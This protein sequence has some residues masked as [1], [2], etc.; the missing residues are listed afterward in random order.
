MDTIN[1]AVGYNSLNKVYSKKIEAKQKD[2][3]KKE[4]EEVIFEKNSS[5]QENKVKGDY[6]HLKDVK[7]TVNKSEIEAMKNELDERI[8]DSFLQMVKESIEQQNQGYKYAIEIA[9]KERSDEIKP[10]MIEQA[11]KDV[12]EGGYWSV[13]KTADRILKFAKILSGGDPEKAEMLKESFL[14]GFE[15][16]EKAWGGELPEISKRTKEA[17]LEGFDNWNGEEKK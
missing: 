10:E 17:V 2:S 11:K 9:L 8:K 3:S 13:E 6:S 7:Y 16:A 5:N 15:E 14:Q 4:S 1:S 12:A